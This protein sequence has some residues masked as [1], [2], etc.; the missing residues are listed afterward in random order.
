M[1]KLSGAVLIILSA[2]ILGTLIARDMEQKLKFSVDLKNGFLYIKSYISLS[3]SVISE[4]LKKGA[5][6]AGSGSFIFSECADIM[7]N[8]NENFETAWNIACEKINDKKLLEIL[9]EVGKRLGKNSAEEEI[10][11][12]ENVIEKLEIYSAL[13]EKKISSEGKIIKKSGFIL[14][15]LVAILLF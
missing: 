14:G 2:G 6:F 5:Q 3:V 11:F 12:L 4:V 1:L 13:Q 7:I 15:I 9:S 10:S 8:K